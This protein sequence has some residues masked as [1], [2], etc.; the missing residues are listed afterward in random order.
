MHALAAPSWLLPSICV[1]S[2]SQLAASLVGVAAEMLLK[3][4]LPR[5]KAAVNS[6]DAPDAIQHGCRTSRSSFPELATSHPAWLQDLE[7]IFSRFGN[8]TSCDIIKDWKTGDSLCYAFLGFDS[9]E[10]C[11]EAYFKMNNCLIDDRRIKVGRA[12]ALLVRS[13]WLHAEAPPC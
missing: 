11:E 13:G 12:S 4:L 6:S 2:V 1:S 9:D 7:I 8:I 10:A 5:S 3:Q